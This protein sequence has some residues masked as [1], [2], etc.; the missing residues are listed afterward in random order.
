MSSSP[1]LRVAYCSHA[2]AKSAVTRW[3]YSRS[4]PA[5]KNIR[6]GVWEDDRFVGVVLFGSGA[7]PQAADP[8]GLDRLEVCEL[9]RIALVD[10]H[11]TPVS[12]IVRVAL[13][14]LKRTNPGIRLVVSYA[15]PLHDHTG[16][17]YQAGNWIFAG[18]TTGTEHFVTTRSGKFVHSKTLRTGRRGYATKLLA[19]GVI[20]SRKFWKYKYL[21]PLDR[22]TR[23][24]I[25]PLAKPY[26]KRAKVGGAPLPEESRRCDADPSAPV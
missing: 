11:A 5:G 9:T 8:F 22:E 23:E 2:A 4:V 14:I 18:K 7:A 16:G 26:P 21:Y 17:I 6:L 20:E 24:K 25:L 10:G 12:R 1:E 3:H 13:S 19:E 15:D